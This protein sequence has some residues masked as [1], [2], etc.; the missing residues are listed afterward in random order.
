MINSQYQNDIITTTKPKGGNIQRPLL[1]D[2]ARTVLATWFY[3][4]RELNSEPR[5]LIK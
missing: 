5:A 4:I 1:D 2:S 3:Y